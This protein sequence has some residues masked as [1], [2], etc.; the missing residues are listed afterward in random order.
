MIDKRADH[1]DRF[2]RREIEEWSVYCWA[3]DVDGICQSISFNQSIYQSNSPFLPLTLSRLL[4]AIL[5]FLLIESCRGGGGRD[6]PF[7]VPDGRGDAGAVFAPPGVCGVCGSFALR[8]KSC[9]D[10]EGVPSCKK[11]KTY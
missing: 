8:A 6:G 1:L 2:G 4:A 10:D 5:L 9:I 7:N 11:M 3:W